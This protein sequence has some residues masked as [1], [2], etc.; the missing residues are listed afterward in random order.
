MALLQMKEETVMRELRD[1]LL[2][3]WTALCLLCACAAVLFSVS[4]CTQESPEPGEDTQLRMAVIPK[5]TAHPYWKSVH[6]GAEKAADE[7]DVKTFWVGAENENDR[8]GQIEIVQNFISRQVD[9]IV[10]APLDKVALARPVEAA[11][12]Q[13]I[14]VIIIDSGLDSDAQ[15]SFVATDNKKGGKMGARRLAEIMGDKGRAIMMR[16]MPGSASTGNREE[17]FMEEMKQNHPD[18]ELVSTDQYGGATKESA[19]K[20]GQDLL[21]KYPDIDG[22]FCPNESSA[23][24]MLRALET[25]GMAGKVKYVGFDAS[26]SLVSGLREGAIQGLV[27]QD[28][29]TMGYEG[30]KTAV[31]VVKGKKVPERV[32]TRTVVVTPENVDDEEIQ[33]I[34]N[35]PIDK[36]LK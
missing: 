26:E 2:R 4:A 34:I 13:G 12:A 36:W 30:V 9:A 29:F 24:G 16:Y 15:S 21:N 19:F 1:M 23:F 33:K 20:T 8:Q 7:F 31:D 35:P 3:P 6:A 5:G 32:R 27:A 17:G 22:V 10:L 14:P 18:I 11:V 28:P 25:K